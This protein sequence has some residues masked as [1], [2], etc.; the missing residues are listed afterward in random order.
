MDSPGYS[1]LSVWRWGVCCVLPSVEG[2]CLRCLGCRCLNH[3]WSAALHARGDCRKRSS[4]TPSAVEQTLDFKDQ[5]SS[6]TLHPCCTAAASLLQGL[7]ANWALMW[8]QLPSCQW[9]AIKKIT[10]R[11]FSKS[12]NKGVLAFAL[13]HITSS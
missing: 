4:A 12:A 7:Q 11:S 10:L 3:A 6:F 8:S 2:S 13:Y 1:A 9:T 5:I